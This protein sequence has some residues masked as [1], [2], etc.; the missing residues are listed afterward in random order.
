MQRDLSEVGDLAGLGDSGEL[1]RG[2][3]VTDA[4]AEDAHLALNQNVELV[5]E[6]A[7]LNQVAPPTGRAAPIGLDKFGG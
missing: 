1:K 4:L 3:A 2:R 7:L 5:A 6:L